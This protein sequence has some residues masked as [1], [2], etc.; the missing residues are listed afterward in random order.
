MQKQPGMYQQQPMMHQQPGMMQQHPGMMQQQLMMGQP[1]MQQQP[2]M[3]QQQPMMQQ[4]MMGQPMMQQQPGM[5]QQQPMMQQAPPQTYA[6]FQFVQFTG[7]VRRATY[8]PA[9]SN[10]DYTMQVN[11]MIQRGQTSVTG[12][13]HTVL[14]DP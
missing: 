1:M 2:G 11:A 10:N 7:P 4:P 14:G 5:Y 13:I 12:G 3:Y 8:G 6:D 9:G